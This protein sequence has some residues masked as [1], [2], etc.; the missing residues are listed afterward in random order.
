[1]ERAGAVNVI[2][3]AQKLARYY[4]QAAAPAG[5]LIPNIRRNPGCRERQEGPLPSGGEKISRNERADDRGVGI[6][7]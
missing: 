7:A 3:I 6:V 4:G 5:N 1:M 2:P